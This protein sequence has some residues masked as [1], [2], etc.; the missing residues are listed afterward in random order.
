MSILSVDV[1]SKNM[2]FCKLLP[3]GSAPFFEITH[4]YTLD[5]HADTCP[6]Q[7][8]KLVEEFKLVPREIIQNNAT[9]LIEAQTSQNI[10]MKVLSHALQALFL[11]QSYLPSQVVFASPHAKLKICDMQDVVAGNKYRQNK[12]AA[13]K[14]CEK[15][16]QEAVAARVHNS[17][18][19]YNVFVNNKKQDDLADSLLQAVCRLPQYK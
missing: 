7:V 10:K 6:K 1:G 8:S 5:C 19:F 13:V 9:V 12:M 16:L 14:K 18:H 17:E 4:W 3:T 15:L 2:M 11:S